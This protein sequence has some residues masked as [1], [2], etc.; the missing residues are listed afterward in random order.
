[1]RQTRREGLYGASGS[2]T[3]TMAA[4]WDCSGS[5]PSSVFRAERH[6]DG[7]H[8]EFTT[9]IS[10]CTPVVVSRRTVRKTRSRAYSADLQ[11]QQWSFLRS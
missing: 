2:G 7:S 8:F 3:A 5:K 11:P 9:N 1:M 10:C 6:T 4:P